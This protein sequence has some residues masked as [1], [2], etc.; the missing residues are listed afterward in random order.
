MD[1][2]KHASFHLALP[3]LNVNDTKSFYTNTLGAVLGR[4][5]EKWVDVNLFGNQI[6]F[7]QSGDFS[8]SYKEYRFE[9]VILPSFHFGVIVGKEDWNSL[10]HKLSQTHEKLIKTK[11]LKNKVG[12]HDSFFVVDPNGFTLEFKC[13][14]DDSSTFAS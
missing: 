12:E 8:F 2:Q 13:F 6:T 11:F 9:E 7:T 10:Y 1:T 4:N 5:T 3:C 14:L